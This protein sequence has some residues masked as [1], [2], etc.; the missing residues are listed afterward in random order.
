MDYIATLLTSI[1]TALSI[2]ESM[3]KSFS[4][5]KNAEYTLKIADLM[6]I[7]ADAKINISELKNEIDNKI[8]QIQKLNNL[9]ETK[10]KLEFKEPFYYM[11]GKPDAY[12]SRCWDKDNRLIHVGPLVK[13][14][15]DKIRICPECK[16]EYIVEQEKISMGAIKTSR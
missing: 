3:S 11:Q 16:N 14:N 2:T 6:N 13:T 4:I 12:C 9:L 5:M 15:I 8:S 7:L 1:Q 10:E